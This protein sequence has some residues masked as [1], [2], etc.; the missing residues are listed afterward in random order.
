MENN[1][2]IQQGP[3]TPL[4]PQRGTNALC[5]T[6]FI[7]ALIG[8]I[9]I[10]VLAPIAGLI[11]GIVGLKQVKRSGE[12]GRGFAIAGIWLSAVQLVLAALVI[13]VFVIMFVVMGAS[14]MAL[15]MMK[16]SADEVKWT[17]PV[18]SP[19]RELQV[20]G[21]FTV[22]ISDQ[23]QAM[24]IS[25]W[26]VT[27]NQVSITQGEGVMKITPAD[28]Y[29]LGNHLQYRH[30]TI[31]MGSDVLSKLHV[32]G[33]GKVECDSMIAGP[34]GAVLINSAGSGD[35]RVKR[36]DA[37]DAKIVL[38]GS[39][40]I[41]IDGGEADSLEVTVS[42]S[43]KF[44]GKSLKAV[45]ARATVSGSGSAKIFASEA[46]SG[47]VSGSGKINVYGNPPVC[48]KTVAGSGRI[49]VK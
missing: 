41:D 4:P 2:Y 20:S 30:V 10:P 16:M 37:G 29:N 5:L 8:W 28:S 11:L 26:G 43:G 6:S 42:G 21:P 9:A 44:D 1:S 14:M 25:G 17:I 18:E 31:T 45:R 32:R 33:S 48:E 24:E 49:N 38:S 19:V 39:S 12:E 13:L 15:P 46:F 36:L 27:S 23:E 22:K 7:S 3:M 47:R 35:V 40:D 34:S